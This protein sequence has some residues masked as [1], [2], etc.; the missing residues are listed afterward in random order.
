MSE[1]KDQVKGLWFPD[2]NLI[3]SIG[4]HVCRV[5]KSVLASHS[6]VVADMLSV[7]QPDSADMLDGIPAMTLPYLP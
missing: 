7:P 2:G 1:G 3:I 4:D 6:P 5:H